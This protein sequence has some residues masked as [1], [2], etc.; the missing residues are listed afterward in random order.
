M[1]LTF[2]IFSL[3]VKWH[4]AESLIVTNQWIC[5]KKIKDARKVYI[6]NDHSILLTLK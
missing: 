3:A 5:V 2:N 6:R 4:L 1:Q